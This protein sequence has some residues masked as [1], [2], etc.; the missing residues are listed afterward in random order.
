MVIVIMTTVSLQAQSIS[1]T[2]VVGMK[3]DTLIKNY[4][5]AEG[6]KLL[7]GK[8]NWSTGN[9]SGQQIGHF[10]NTNP[11]FPFD[12]GIVMTTGN[13]NVAPGPNN[14]ENA[15]SANG[16]T[17]AT[18]DPDLSAIDNR[19]Q[20]TNVLEFD[21]HATA[22]TFAFTYIFGSEEYPEYV[23]SSYN[24]IFAFFLTGPDP[25]TGNIT[26]KNIAIIPGTTL[27]VTINSLNG[28]QV[29]FYGSSS[30][31]TSLNYSQYYH[32]NQGGTAVEYNGYT[33]PLTATSYL[34][35]C[36]EYHMKLSIANVSDQ[37]YDSGVFL[38]KGSFYLP[39]LD[40]SDYTEM[41]D[42]DTIIKN[43]NT[44]TIDLSYSEPAR[45]YLNISIG[46]LGTSTAEWG[47]DFVINQIN[48]NGSSTPVT[49]DNNE[50][51]FNQGDT[52]I[53]LKIASTPNASFSQGEVKTIKLVLT[54]LLCENFIYLDGHSE[55]L[56][57]LDTLTYYMVDN[58]LIIMNDTTVRYCNECTYV[59]ANLISGSEPLTYHWTPEAGITNPN[60]RE[61]NAHISN[62]T[63]FTVTAT[64]RWGCLSDTATYAV[65]I[66]KIPTIEGHYTI[67]PKSGCIPMEVEFN[68]Q[69]TPDYSDHVW[70]LEVDDFED[71]TITERNFH[72]IYTE[73]G[74]Y[75]VSLHTISAPGC[76]DSIILNNVISVSDYP[77]SDF[78]FEPM[79]PLNGRDVY[80]TDASSGADITSYQWSFGDGGGSSEKD[81]T[82]AYHVSTNEIFTISHIVT[83][84]NGCADTSFNVISIEDKFV[85][86]VPNSFT[87]NDDEINDIFLPTTQD[88]AEYELTIYDR[89]GSVVFTTKDTAQGWDGTTMGGKPCPSGVYTYII[90]YV[91]YSNIQET[92]I[93]RGSITLVR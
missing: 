3:P 86:Y 40:I 82:H 30:Y 68:S 21:F 35:S 7:N 39:V 67:S 88:I 70:V 75:T 12:A 34:S 47:N 42:N 55:P 10:S 93:K 87:P 1:V 2:N 81:A 17:T 27:P 18:M 44:K 28:G 56:T 79:E 33:V 63:V 31:C 69:V 62:N 48:P 74:E 13:I 52:L 84:K 11:S 37:A 25:Y 32:N 41:E 76:E 20:T 77:T 71:T 92:D 50:I 85:L 8:W 26:T 80:F 72:Y 24:D 29:G 6:V 61:S 22:D 9:I 54:Q 66:T 91:K 60:A 45:Q 46:V 57:Q 16:V 36:H 73:P 14:V 90:Q 53:R 38:K 89:H 23:C 65:D 83:N 59:K 51:T 78:S 43:C 58:N 19:I 49:A 5:A 15:S 64:D 4:L